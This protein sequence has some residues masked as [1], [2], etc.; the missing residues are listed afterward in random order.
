MRIRCYRSQSSLLWTAFLI[1]VDDLSVKKQDKALIHAKRARN[2]KTVLMDPKDTAVESAQFRF[3]VKKMFKLQTIGTGTLD[4]TKM[5]C[6]EGK[7]TN[8]FMGSEGTYFTLCQDMSD[9]PSASR[10]SALDTSEFEKKLT[11]PRGAVPF[12][13]VTIAAYVK[14]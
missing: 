6:H 10:G 9:L 3:W 13:K 2:I 7:P 4:C 12:T 5:I 1:Y 8:L 11:S 14:A